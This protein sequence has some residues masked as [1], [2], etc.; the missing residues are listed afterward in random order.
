MIFIL[1]TYWFCNNRWKAYC[2]AFSMIYLYAVLPGAPFHICDVLSS[3]GKGY[4][5]PQIKLDLQK[6]LILCHF[7]VKCVAFRNY[8]TQPE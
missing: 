3:Q 5:D 1:L 8:L 4:Q 6:S 2:Y 7:Y